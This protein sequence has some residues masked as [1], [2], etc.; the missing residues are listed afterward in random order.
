MKTT[1]E[2]MRDVVR[3]EGGNISEEDYLKAIQEACIAE[4]RDSSITSLKSNAFS[5]NRMHKAG[6]VRVSIG[7][8]KQV[9]EI[10][11]IKATLEGRRVETTPIMMMQQS[12]I[13]VIEEQKTATPK[14]TP[15]GGVFYGIPR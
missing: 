10:E 6:I 7:K 15:Q 5:A 3:K 14:A 12:K 2:I 11:A 1:I 4:G 8:D 9:W 13:G